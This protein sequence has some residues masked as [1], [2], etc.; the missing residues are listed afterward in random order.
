[1]NDKTMETVYGK[2]VKTSYCDALN[3]MLVSKDSR[4]TSDE[5]VMMIR[6]RLEDKPITVPVFM[7]FYNWLYNQFSDKTCH[8]M[9][10]Y[11]PSYKDTAN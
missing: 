2:P 1:M 11:T 3:E 4:F 8:K 7:K 9:A 10:K 6:Q 5:F